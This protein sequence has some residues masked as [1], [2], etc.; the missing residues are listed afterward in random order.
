VL[1]YKTTLVVWGIVA[2][3]LKHGKPITDEAVILVLIEL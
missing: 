3:V 2:I 1:E